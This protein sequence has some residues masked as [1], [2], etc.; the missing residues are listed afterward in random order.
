[1]ESDQMEDLEMDEHGEI[2][3]FTPEK[4]QM[5]QDEAMAEQAID[6]AFGRKS[7]DK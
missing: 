1:M 5:N 2:K 6:P 3:I 7:K 4:G